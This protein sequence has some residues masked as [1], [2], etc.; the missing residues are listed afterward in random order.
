MIFVKQIYMDFTSSPEEQERLALLR[1]ER[2]WLLNVQILKQ[3]NLLIVAFCSFT[4]F[5]APGLRFADSLYIYY[6]GESVKS[7]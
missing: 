3:F 4:V 5:I 2:I 1:I 7:V 6:M